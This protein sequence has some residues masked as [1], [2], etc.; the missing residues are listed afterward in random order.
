M[1]KTPE[2]KVKDMIRR[3]LI[4]RGF[5]QVAQGCTD[6]RRWFW[7]PVQGLYSVQGMSDYL[8]MCDGKPWFIEAKSEDGEP[9]A[10]QADFLA[11]AESS[12]A[13]TAIVRNEHDMELLLYVICD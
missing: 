3:K 9:T 6:A 2:G 7:M 5:M 13:V 11:M 12:G 8:G 10:H 1:A 4:E